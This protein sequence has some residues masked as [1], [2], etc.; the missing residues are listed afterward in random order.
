MKY[1]FRPFD[2]SVKLRRH[3]ELPICPKKKQSVVSPQHVSV[4]RTGEAPSTLF[5]RDDAPGHEDYTCSET[6]PC[7]NKACCSKL[8]GYCNYGEAACGSGGPGPNEVCWSNCD[9]KAECGRF[10]DPPG[11]KCPLN[12]CCSEFGMY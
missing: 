1:L 10:S 5:K 7:S 6:K 12:V 9:A 11:K 2:F 8:T 4:L 3:E